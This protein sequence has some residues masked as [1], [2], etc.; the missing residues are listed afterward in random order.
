VYVTLNWYTFYKY[1]LLLKQRILHTRQYVIIRNWLF[2]FCAFLSL[3]AVFL[4][5][6]VYNVIVLQTKEL[7]I[8]RY[9]LYL[10]IMSLSF[11]LLNFSLLLIPQILYGLPIERLSNVNTIE[12]AAELEDMSLQEPEPHA[13]LDK[14]TPSFYSK[15]YIAQIEQ[16][17]KK[18]E[19]DALFIDP[20]FKMEDIS[21]ISAIPL[22]HLAYFF[23]NF[24]DQKFIEWRSN[25]RISHSI[26]LMND[27]AMDDHSFEVIAQL[28]AFSSRQTFIRAFKSKM[29]KTPSDFYREIKLS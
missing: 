6:G 28:C 25:L 23:G 13:D 1:K 20:S 18:A 9:Y 27:G 3:E 7:F 14:V 10:T 29:G 4:I 8:Q 11:L 16:W 19:E 12:L 24:N 5:F 17:I 22:H 15:D 21:K 2:I 26:K